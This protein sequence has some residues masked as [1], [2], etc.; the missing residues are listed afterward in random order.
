MVFRADSGFFV[1]ALMDFLDAG[2]HGYLIKVKLNGTN[3]SGSSQYHC[4]TC[5][6]YGVLELKER[7]TEDKERTHY[8]S[9]S[10]KIQY[11]RD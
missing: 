6:A 10:R 8:K 9:L 1:G 3:A 11:A 2:G 4:K 7:S 5:G